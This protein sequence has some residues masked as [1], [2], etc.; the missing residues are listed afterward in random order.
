[1]K[2][3]IARATFGPKDTRLS[4]KTKDRSVNVRFAGE[5]ASI[6]YQIARGKV[7]RAVHDDVVVDE[8]IQRIRARQFRFVCFYLNVRINVFDA[9]ARGSN[10][11]SPDIFCSVNDLPLKI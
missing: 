8:K 6:V 4:F 9:V 2:A 3:T 7:V 5:Y 1:M 11:R 10:L